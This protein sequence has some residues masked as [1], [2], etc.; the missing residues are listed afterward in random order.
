M[1]DLKDINFIYCVEYNYRNH[2]SCSES[3]CND[4]GI[5]RC[6]TIED[7][8]IKEVRTSD[9]VSEIYNNL[10][11]NSKATKRNIKINSILSDITADVDR[12]TIDR[13]LRCSKIWEESNWNINVVGGYYGQ[14]IDGVYLYDSVAK[15]IQ[16]EIDLALSIESLADRVEFLLKLEYDRVLPELIGKTWKVITVNKSDITIGSKGHLSKV[17]SKQLEFYSKRNYSSIRGIVIQSGDKFRLIDGYH[18]MSQVGEEEVVVLCA[19]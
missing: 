4:E 15:K 16:S 9:V 18:R 7:T 5:C 10:F 1:K 2:T 12:Y 6:G 13:I 8:E 3:G 17:K 19:S 14:E 11:D